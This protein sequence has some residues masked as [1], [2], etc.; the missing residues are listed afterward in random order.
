MNEAE[1]LE[2]LSSKDESGY[3]PTFYTSQDTV[4]RL[5]NLSWRAIQLGLHEIPSLQELVT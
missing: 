1:V 4:V 5:C 3:W 2:S